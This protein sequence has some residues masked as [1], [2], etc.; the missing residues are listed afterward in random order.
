MKIVQ[1]RVALTMALLGALAAA[2]DTRDPLTPSFAAS[3]AGTVAAPSNLTLTVDSYHQIWLAWHDNATNEA[4]YEVWKSTTGPSG[5]FSLFTTYPWPNTAAGGNDGLDPATQYCYKVRAYSML[6]QSGKTRTYSD[7]SNIACATTPALPPPPPVVAAPSDLTVTPVGSGYVRITWTDNATNEDGFRAERSP[8]PTGPWDVFISLLYPNASSTSDPGRGPDQQTCYRVI[9]FNA[10]ANSAPSNV[11]CSAFPA[12]PTGLTATEVDAN[13]IEL[14]WQDNSRLE[15]GY[16]VM[17]ST[18]AQDHTIVAKIPA[19][20]TTYR[21]VPAANVSYSYM[22][23]AT[24]D[25]GFSNVSNVATVTV[26][27]F[28]P[29]NPPGLSQALGYFLGTILLSWSDGVNNQEGYKIERC[30]GTACSDAD[31]VLV[32]TTGPA[33]RSFQDMVG[34][35][36]VVSYRIRA[37]N[38]IGDSA[39]SNVMLGRACDEEI[40]YWSPCFP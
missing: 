25:D 8:L 21:D 38:R 19:N 37:F 34:A 22:V 35:G 6:G 27:V 36:E 30:G 20:S 17:R 4:G 40:D 12:A 14:V 28:T 24:R 23:H 13:M 39:P 10:Q 15:D 18:N 11:D 2:C 3:K 33:A 16:E 7:F 5:T 32:A 9:A 29:P 1:W 26:G 31:F